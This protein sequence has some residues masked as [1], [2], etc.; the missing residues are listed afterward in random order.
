MLDAHSRIACGS[1]TQ[2]FERMQTNKVRSVVCDKHWPQRAI[3]WL[4]RL[5]L[6]GKSV[7]ESYDLSEQDVFQFLASQ[8]PSEA[9]L[10]ESITLLNSHNKR[11]PRWAEKTPRHM[12]HYK[13][14]ISAFPDCRFVRIV[15][16]PRDSALSMRQLPWASDQFLANFYLWCHWFDSSHEDYLGTSNTLTIRYED[17]IEFPRETLSKVCEHVGEAFEDSMIHYYKNAD[18]VVTINE[19]WKNK[20]HDPID[21]S[22]R[23]RWKTELSEL[24]LD[25]AESVGQPWLNEFDYEYKVRNKKIVAKQK[26]TI[27]EFE[28]NLP[29]ILRLANEGIVVIPTD[30]S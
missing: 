24:E 5:K 13:R 29:H 28:D 14:I 2:F 27:Q 6:A 30:F 3:Y 7:L 9:A 1:E 10:L 17:L 16:D 12:L 11:K 20:V 21:L 19:P 4:S 8:P 15:R 22:R 26:M 23:F 25:I 18:S